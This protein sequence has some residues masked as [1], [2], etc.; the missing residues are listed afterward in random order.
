MDFSLKY[1]ADIINDVSCF[2]HD[3]QSFNIIKNK[4]IWK[5]IHHMQGTPQTMQI[6]PYYKNV[7]LEIYDF[8]EKEIKKLKKFK[9]NQKIILDPGIGFGKNLKHNLMIL[10][11]ISIFHSLGFPILIG[12]SRKKFI[13]QISGKYDT[14]ERIG[15]TL[16]SI[17]FSF[18][19][20][21]KMFRVHNVEEVKQGLKVFEALLNTWKK[22]ILEQ[23]V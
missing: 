6:N 15:G 19:Q 5:I 2:K 8:F 10:N 11:K 18:S 17:I 13:N 7:L 3:S 1:G 16:S 20:G 14:K 4:N 21:I 23:M 9:H 22:N 12:T